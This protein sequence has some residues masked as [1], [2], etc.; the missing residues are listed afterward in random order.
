MASPQSPLVI[1]I[2]GGGTK[3]HGV[4]YSE[5]R[6]VVAEAHAAGS[7]PHS[8][9]ENVVR[10]ALHGLVDQLLDRGATTLDQVAGICVGMA[11]VDR[12]KDREFIENILLERIGQTAR[13]LVVNDAIVAMEAVLGR[14]HGILLIAGTG[15]ICLGYN[16]K[17]RQSTRCG[18]WGHLLADEGSGYRIGLRALVAV[19]HAHDKRIAPTSLT[20]RVL[21]FLHLADPTDL[22]GWTYMQGN[23]KTEVAAVA[24]LVHE[25]AAQGD[26]A[27][28]DIL[29]EEAASLATLVVPVY[30]QLFP[31]EEE[32]VQIALWGG[33]LVHIEAYRKRVTDALE[34]TGLRLEP[35]VREAQAVVGA[36]RH[37]L[38]HL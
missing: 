22:I 31:E 33:N 18:G 8:N 21:E 30:T 13:L 25:E 37:M 7:N 11:G 6:G 35:V 16:E 2:D 32:P 17:T 29:A 34:K 24:P 1:G 36:A 38:H 15:S 28:N 19:L 5:E 23:G 20:A 12:P 9:P 10:A 14:L 26:A 27:A 3:T 4:L